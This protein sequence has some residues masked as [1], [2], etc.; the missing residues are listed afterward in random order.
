MGKHYGEDSERIGDPVG[1]NSHGATV[2]QLM[3]F[4]LLLEQGRLV[5]EPASA[6]MRDIF[7]LAEIPRP[8]QIRQGLTGQG[9]VAA[10]QM[11]LMGQ[12]AA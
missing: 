10:A 9:S 6:A 1:D 8:N 3:R 7:K 5:S 12:L 11:G 4:Y 2:R